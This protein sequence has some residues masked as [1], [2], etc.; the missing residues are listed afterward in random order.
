MFVCERKRWVSEAR[1]DSRLTEVK[2]NFGQ[3]NKKDE[4]KENCV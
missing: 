4:R 2:E 3:I 1:D